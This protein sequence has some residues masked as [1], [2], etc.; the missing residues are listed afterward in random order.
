MTQ[1]GTIKHD[2][3]PIGEIAKPPFVRLPDPLAMFAR[4][5]A[6]LREL[7]GGHELHAYLKFLADLC[8]VQHRLQTGLP[9]AEL[10]PA[11]VIAR[12][13][14][15]RMPPLDRTRFGRD[16]ALDAV[17]ARLLAMAEQVEMPDK[18]RIALERVKS[19]RS[20][21]RND[22]GRRRAGERNTD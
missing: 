11:D 22:F 3:I 6:R 16:G 8:D 20:H 17:W 14:Q 4:R 21:R 5:A 1:V 10:P 15:F 12:S 18:A 2:P 7:A 9:D 19:R 13:R